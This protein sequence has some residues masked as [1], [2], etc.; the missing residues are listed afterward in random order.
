MVQI[1][2]SVFFGRKGMSSLIRSLCC[3]CGAI[4]APLYDEE[5]H[6]IEL[7]RGNL[8]F[9]LYELEELEKFT[10]SDG[11]VAKNP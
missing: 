4:V 11:S 5:P 3:C 7:Y 6:L 10:N 9:E 8:Y 1:I 2:D